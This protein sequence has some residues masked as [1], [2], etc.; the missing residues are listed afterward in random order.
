MQDDRDHTDDSLRAER[1][2]TD[3]AAVARRAIREEQADV[4][5]ENARE[6]ADTVLDTA[7]ERVDQ[8]LDAAEPGL[9]VREAIV[10]GRA[11]EDEVLRGE[12]AAADATLW[13]AREEQA[14]VLSALRP[15]ERD[16]T[17]RDLLTERNRADDKITHRD[18]FLGMVAHDLRSLLCGVA[19][20]AS[21]LAD[22]ASDSSEGRLTVTAV[23]RLE[24]YVARMN[25]LIGDLVDVVSI[26]AGKLAVRRQSCDGAALLSEAVETFKLRAREEGISLHR[27]TS[28]EKL[29]AELDYDRIS[30]VLAN[31]IANA[32]KFTPRGGHIVVRGERTANG[33]R[34]SVTDTGIGIPS[35][36]LEAIF[37]RFWQAGESDRRGLGLGLHISK[38]IVDAH[39][40][41][42]WAESKLGAGSVF[43][44]T[45]PDAVAVAT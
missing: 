27:E 1:S 21:R 30:Q 15:L 26:D 22:K 45:I 40:G 11:I 29:A 13:R 9:E 6:R 36:Q 42:I 19:L 24:R 8:E 18:D 20:E 25:R 43:V 2:S 37:Q 33:L 4:V 32:L 35:H 39:G 31:L 7:R 23:K 14:A 38:C 16:Q 34:V 3:Q 5:V 44:F 28:E 10:A 12:R 41:R 17:D